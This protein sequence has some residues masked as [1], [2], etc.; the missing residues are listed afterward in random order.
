MKNLGK[1]Y[2]LLLKNF[3]PQS[4][5]PGPGLA[6]GQWHLRAVQGW[7]TPYQGVWFLH[8]A[9]CEQRLLPWIKPSWQGECCPAFVPHNDL[10]SENGTSQHRKA[11]SCPLTLWGS[12]DTL[13]DLLD[14]SAPNVAVVGLG[15]LGVLFTLE[16]LLHTPLKLQPLLPSVCLELFLQ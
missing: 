5:R 4:R 13:T 9:P 15:W 16:L 1:W 11:H 8:G 10:V 12:A 3:K 6:L 14:T 2:S 7:Q